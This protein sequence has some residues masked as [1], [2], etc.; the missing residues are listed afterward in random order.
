MGESREIKRLNGQPPAEKYFPLLI[1]RLG[2]ESLT[3]NMMLLLV[4]GF[5]LSLLKGISVEKQLDIKRKS[6]R[7]VKIRIMWGVLWI[8]RIKRMM[9]K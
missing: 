3:V 1:E 6:Q 8:L 4:I 2:I 7:N 5:H 9:S